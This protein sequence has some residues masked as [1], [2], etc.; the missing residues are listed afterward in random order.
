MASPR[1]V[2]L[3]PLP[4]PPMVALTSLYMRSLRLQERLRATEAK[5][6]RTAS[7]L[8]KAIATRL[9]VEVV[10]AESAVVAAKEQLHLQAMLSRAQCAN[11]AADAALQVELAARRRAEDAAAAAI[12]LERRLRASLAVAE[13]RVAAATASLESEACH[14][15]EVEAATVAAAA[16]EREGMLRV[17]LVKTARYSCCLVGC[18]GGGSDL[19]EESG[20][21]AR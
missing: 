14:R 19:A 16:E 13:R 15:T 4:W 5:L 6:K 8:N 1:R 3:R 18:V 12:Q 17:A 7:A 9:Q 11:A 20:G 2:G 21:S 10:A